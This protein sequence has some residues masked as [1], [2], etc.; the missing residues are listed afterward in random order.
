MSPVERNHDNEEVFNTRDRRP[1]RQLC[2]AS[3]TASRAVPPFDAA[4]RC[5]GS[6]SLSRDHDAIAPVA[7]AVEPAGGTSSA[8]APS[9]HAGN[10]HTKLRAIRDFLD[11]REQTTCLRTNHYCSRLAS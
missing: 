6:E 2:R 5:E 11:M 10:V 1:N 3:G 4:S 8:A 9:R 7:G